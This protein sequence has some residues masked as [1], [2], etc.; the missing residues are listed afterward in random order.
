[1]KQLQDGYVR[2]VALSFFFLCAKFYIYIKAPHSQIW[3][4]V[5][6]GGTG[7]RTPHFWSSGRTP[8]LFDERQR[9]IQSAC[10]LASFITGSCSVPTASAIVLMLW[11]FDVG[12]TAIGRSS[13]D[14][15]INLDATQLLCMPRYCWDA[16]R[17]LSKRVGRVNTSCYVRY[18]TNSVHSTPDPARRSLNSL[19][20]DYRET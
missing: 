15:L 12:Y 11:L 18:M 9:C 7:G 14:M 2:F 3:Y 10:S 19:A 8:A 4:G 16:C 6:L 5:T 17:D 1:V 20:I 13:E